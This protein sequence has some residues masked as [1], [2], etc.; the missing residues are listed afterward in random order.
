MYVYTHVVSLSLGDYSAESWC[1][2][3][4]APMLGT[5]HMQAAY[6]YSADISCRDVTTGSAPESQQREG[7]NHLLCIWNAPA[8]DLCPMSMRCVL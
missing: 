1:V 6:L 8:A 4:A 3:I 2:C 7:D 5:L